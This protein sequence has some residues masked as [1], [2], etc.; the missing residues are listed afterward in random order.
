MS[1]GVAEKIAKIS[2]FAHSVLLLYE[3]NVRS[4]VIPNPCQPTLMT[5]HSIITQQSGVLCLSI[6]NYRN[7]FRCALTQPPEVT[8]FG[9]GC[10]FEEVTLVFTDFRST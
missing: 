1:F 2:N 9:S 10:A 5:L 4:M 3:I 8:E 7:T 6:K